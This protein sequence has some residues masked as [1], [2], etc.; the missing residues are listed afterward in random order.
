[1]TDNR[2]AGNGHEV[3]ADSYRAGVRQHRP[4]RGT[5]GRPGYR[6]SSRRIWITWGF[7]STLLSPP[8]EEM[9]TQ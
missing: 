7:R 8:T 4:Q 2:S 6:I 1:M 3:L 5:Y 9:S